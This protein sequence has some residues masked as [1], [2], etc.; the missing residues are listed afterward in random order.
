MKQLNE[1]KRMQQLAG[2]INESQLN[3]FTNLDNPTVDQALESG[4]FQEITPDTE[5]AVGDDV[6]SA[7]GYF[8]EI[9]K[10]IG[11]KYVIEDAD[12][13]IRKVGKDKLMKFYLIRK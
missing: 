4:D 8:G 12:G 3:E 10:I 1:I 9:V 13:D 6:L 7:K 11:D 5:I 2:L